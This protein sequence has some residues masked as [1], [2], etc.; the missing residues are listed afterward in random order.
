MIEFIVY[1][2]QYSFI[3][4]ALPLSLLFKRTPEYLLGVP[5]FAETVSTATFSEHVLLST[6]TCSLLAGCAAPSG[7]MFIELLLLLVHTVGK[8]VGVMANVE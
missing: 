5:I 4:T 1:T 7:R 2:L 8:H 3:C 6:W